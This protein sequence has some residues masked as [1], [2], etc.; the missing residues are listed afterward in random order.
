MAAVRWVPAHETEPSLK[1]SRHD[2]TGNAA[3]DELAKSITKAWGATEEQ[4]AALI[5]NQLLCARIQGLQVA[6]LKEIQRQPGAGHQGPAADR[7]ARLAQGAVQGPT[8]RNRPP[9]E[10]GPGELR[11]WGPH[12]VRKG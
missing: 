10:M 6:I 9:H 8:R 1:I 11:T 2:H 3:V 7:R 5:A 12:L 4:R